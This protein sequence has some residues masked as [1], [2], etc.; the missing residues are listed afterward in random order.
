MCGSVRL[1]CGSGQLKFCHYFNMM[2][3]DIEERCS[4][5]QAWWDTEYTRRLTRL[6]TMYNVLKFSK[7]FQKGLVRLRFGCG[8]FFNLLMFRTVHS[9]SW[10]SPVQLS[11]QTS[12][13]LTTFTLEVGETGTKWNTG[14]VGT[15][16]IPIM[17]H[18][19]CAT[20]YDM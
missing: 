16:A 6:Q 3:C 4:Y 13:F 19:K 15:R 2:F 14:Q 9:S 12:T 11:W 10:V 5:F 8:Y 7:I 18:K 20:L 1:C 17:K